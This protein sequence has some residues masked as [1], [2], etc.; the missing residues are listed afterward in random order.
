MEINAH[1]D[2][3]GKSELGVFFTNIFNLHFSLFHW[4]SP[5]AKIHA[6]APCPFRH[7]NT[8]HDF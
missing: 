2:S 4:N 6:F 3:E 7:P 8:Y 5:T 1:S